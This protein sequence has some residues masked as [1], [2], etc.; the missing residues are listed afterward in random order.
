MSEQELDQ[1]YTA[2]CEAMAR[3]GERRTPLLLSIVCLALMSRQ[4]S[5]G[6]VLAVIEQ[7]EASCAD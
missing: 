3:V 2:L 6:E 4:P 1:S 5:A 7:A